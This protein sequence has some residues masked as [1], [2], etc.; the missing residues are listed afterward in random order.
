MVRLRE[1]NKLLYDQLYEKT[2]RLKDLEPL[3]VKSCTS[4]VMIVPF[5]TR[6]T[7]PS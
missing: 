4:K 5:R 1:E 2:A 6:R 3:L 7:R